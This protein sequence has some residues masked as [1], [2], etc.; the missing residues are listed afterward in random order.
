MSDTKENVRQKRHFKPI[1]YDLVDDDSKTSNDGTMSKSTNDEKLPVRVPSIYDRIGERLAPDDA[2]E[3]IST[4]RP[5]PRKVG[6]KKRQDSLLEKCDMVVI[7]I[8]GKDTSYK[9]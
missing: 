3:V 9:K 6:R 2:R 5:G 7:V 4:R 8:L 1:V